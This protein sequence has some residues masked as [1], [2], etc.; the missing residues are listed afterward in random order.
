MVSSTEEP[1]GEQRPAFS[2]GSL[3]EIFA[4]YYGSFS[5][6]INIWRNFL[7]PR[8]AFSPQSRGWEKMR[9]LVYFQFSI[10]TQPLSMLALSAKD[11]ALLFGKCQILTMAFS[12]GKASQHVPRVWDV[13]VHFLMC[14]KGPW[15]VYGTILCS[16]R[17]GK[18]NA[19]RRGILSNFTRGESR[20]TSQPSQNS[21]RR[22]PHWH[23]HAAGTSQRWLLDVF[24]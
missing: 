22:L 21:S 19:R 17:C 11:L 15:R 7:Y 4:V 13:S 9:Q 18:C 6:A 23:L 3:R 8:I 5:A 12:P 1:G 2:S 20:E 24:Q 10:E 14:W 16:Y